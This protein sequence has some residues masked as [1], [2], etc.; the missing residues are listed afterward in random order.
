MLLRRTWKKSLIWGLFE[1]YK[2]VLLYTF[3]K[4]P[5][6]MFMLLILFQMITYKMFSYFLFVVFFTSCHPVIRS[7]YLA[8]IFFCFLSL[9]NLLQLSSFT[10]AGSWSE[11]KARNIRK[12]F[13][14]FLQT[15]QMKYFFAKKL[16]WH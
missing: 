4:N 5:L 12:L 10:D 3:F 14:F 6:E 9:Q 2:L 11:T 7:I 16:C 8:P 13:P 15:A 1:L